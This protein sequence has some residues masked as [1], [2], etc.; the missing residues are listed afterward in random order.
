MKVF[1]LVSRK[2]GVTESLATAVDWR[3]QMKASAQLIQQPLEDNPP[4]DYGQWKTAQ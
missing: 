2:S 3:L 4:L 1:Y